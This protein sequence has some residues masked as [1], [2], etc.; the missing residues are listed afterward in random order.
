MHEHE[1]EHALQKHLAKVTMNLHYRKHL[2]KGTMHEH[3]LQK[4]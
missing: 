2:A 3:A 4:T 1:H